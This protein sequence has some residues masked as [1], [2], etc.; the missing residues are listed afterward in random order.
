VIAMSSDDPFVTIGSP[1]TLDVTLIKRAYFAALAKTPPHSDPEG[2]RRLRAAYESLTDDKARALAFLRAP[3]DSARELMLFEATWG[4]RIAAVRERAAR[5]QEEA[6]A[7][8]GFV[9]HISRISLDEAKGRA[10]G[11][12]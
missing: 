4:P 12:L 5:A 11:K 6:H 7:V 9:E 3:F 10:A 1:P 2:F 8:E